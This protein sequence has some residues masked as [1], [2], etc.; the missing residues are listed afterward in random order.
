[1]TFILLLLRRT[2]TLALLLLGGVGSVHAER[3]HL[4]GDTVYDEVNNLTWKSCAEGAV[5]IP[6]DA[7]AIRS[8]RCVL[9]GNTSNAYTRNQAMA[10]S[11]DGWRLPTKKDWDTLSNWDYYVADNP[12]AF[13]KSIPFLYEIESSSRTVFFWTSSTQYPLVFF[14]DPYLQRNGN[15]G[16]IVPY[17]PPVTNGVVLVRDGGSSVG[18]FDVTVTKIGTGFGTVSERD[19]FFLYAFSKP[20]NCGPICSSPNIPGSKIYLSVT[21]VAADSKFI[22][23]G[24]ACAGTS[25]YGECVVTMDAAKSITARFDLITSA[26]FTLGI[27]SIGTGSGSVTS[28]PAGINCGST[29][30]ASFSAGTSLTLTATPA[31]GSTFAGWGGACTGLSNC[32]VT[33]STA[34]TVTA[35]FTAIPNPVNAKDLTNTTKF[36]SQAIPANA[37]APGVCSNPSATSKDPVDLATGSYFDEL[38][39][40]QVFAPAPLLMNLSYDSR[41]VGWRHPFK[42]ALAVGTTDV[43]LTWPDSHQSTYRS[44]GSGGYTNFAADAQD[45]LIKNA[46]AS[47]TLI[48]RRQKTYNFSNTGQLLST[49]DRFGF[50]TNLSYLANG[51]LNRV[52]DALSTRFLQFTYDTQNRVVSVSSPGVGTVT[53][54]YNT[55]DDLS[56]VTDALGYTTSFTYDAS[57]RLLTKVNAL[58]ATI[59]TNIYDASTGKVVRQDDGLP[60]TAL[61][62]FSYG[63]DTVTSQPF[64]TYKNRSGNTVRHNFDTS[65]NILKTI[66]PLGNS[67]VYTYDPLTKMQSAET[68]ALNNTTRFT[69]DASGY[70]LTRTD[71]LG[72]VASYAYDADHNIVSI[73]DE[74]GRVNRMTYGTNH[75]LLARTDPNSAV[76][77]YTYDAQGLLATKTDPTGGVT[78]YTYDAMGQLSSQLD[79]A[80]VSTSY[81]Y[82]TAGRMLTRR[83]GAG[84]VWTMTY[85]LMGH[86][87]SVT[88]PLGNTTRYTYDALGR[89]ATKT[90]P[91]GGLTRYAYDIHDNLISM[92]DPLLGVTTFG[93]DADDQLISTTDALGHT[94]TTAR[95][96]KG[97]LTAVTD[98]LGSIS[99]KTY[100][101]ADDLTAM[102]DPL[103]NVTTLGYDA[104]RRSTTISDALGQST[105]LAYDA[106]GRTTRLTDPKGEATSFAYDAIGQLVSATDALTGVA[107]QTFDGNGNRLSFTDPAGN[108]TSFSYDAANRVTRIATADGGATTYTY[109]AQNLVA[110]ATNGRGQIARYTYNAAGRPVTIADPAGTI[111]MTYDANGNVLTVGDAV[112]NSTYAY[113]ASDRI[114]R[115]TDVYGNAIAYGYD[116]VGNLSTLTYPGN[117]VV[118]YTYDAAN[119]MTSVKDWANRVTSYTYD[120]RGSVTAISRANATV[121][122]FT[123][124]ANGRLASLAESF[125]LTA[126]NFGVAFTLDA[127]G[128]IT[129]EVN[130][131]VRAPPALT[132]SVMTYGAD[133]RLATLNGQAVVFDADGNM[134][135]G[136]LN[137]GATSLSYDARSRLTSAGGSTY[138]YNALDNRVGATNAGVTTRYVVD[139]NAALSRVLMETTTTGAPVA[140][141]VYGATGLVSR[142]GAT[143]YQTYHYDL[144]GSTVR[145]ADATGAVT[146]NYGYGPYGELVSSIGTSANPFKYNG[147]DG[148]MTDTNGLYYMRARFYLPEAKR[149]VNRDVLLGRVE[150]TLSLNR[151]GYVFGNPVGMVDP[152]GLDAT[153]NI[154]R[155]TY[156]SR[157]VT[158]TITVSS[159]VAGVGSFNG[160]TLETATAGPNGNKNPI[161]AGSYGAS[162][163]FDH[164]PNRIELLNV[165]GFKNVQIHEGNT[166][167]D[168]EGCFAVGKSRSKNFVGNSNSALSEILKIIKMDGSGRITVNVT[169]SSTAP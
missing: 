93:Y 102:S 104:L 38:T 26:T 125:P 16:Y 75:Q 113:D 101:A 129:S 132:S 164:T 67:V 10:I 4:N 110:T 139:P 90:T 50:V 46:D 20:I 124:D 27:N 47:F 112:G 9:V 128:N 60:G 135:S 100:N 133:N 154:N 73:S 82:D 11:Q 88:N 158:G 40:M 137:G 92:T 44:N 56:S 111:T 168:V 3:F 59:V 13:V 153:I 41:M 109:N 130:T 79:S 37:N 70:I 33:M 108:R 119:R 76:T 49:K 116:A 65:L 151:Y 123:Y 147:R 98:A 36:N 64:T 160:F 141:Y 157:S 120:A 145:L 12:Y 166:V 94:S 103:N 14:R 89:L 115:F 74:A 28:A 51:N 62:Q 156:T 118:T 163:R 169:G 140:Y 24:G 30:S 69:Y 54:A 131:P 21:Q 45:K 32:A 31:I 122:T 29:C 144:R 66:D 52:T 159:D 1:M 126:N 165:L 80:G 162:M 152:S 106:L 149:F 35:S 167:N 23:W 84:N 142:E 2:A 5:Y 143:G 117:K 57:H 91:L 68:N 17:L 114:R 127:N 48:D 34:Q 134:T 81:T 8:K 71:P 77:A 83:D 99:R 72:K 86:V 121:S 161:P 155:D 85:D 6:K 25:L 43:V 61:E 87:L 97:R 78:R 42:Y 150:Q 53:L 39:V 138:I 105:G 148:V 107:A 22:G 19:D 18:P 15:F 96:A 7:N 146:D 136:R 63:T 95:D 55:A 58:G